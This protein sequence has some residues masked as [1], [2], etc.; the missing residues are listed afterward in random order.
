MA[1]SPQPDL[2]AD[3]LGGALP[4]AGHDPRPDHVILGH[5]RDGGRG[6]Q[7][8][9]RKR[10]WGTNNYWNTNSAGIISTP[11]AWV[12]G[13][14]AEFAAGTNATAASTVTVNGTI[15]GVAGL[16]FDNGEGPFTLTGGTLTLAGTPSIEVDATTAM[17]GSALAGTVGFTKKGTGT[18]VLSG[19]GTYTGATNVNAGILSVQSAGALGT[20]AN[21]SN[22]TVASGATLQLANNAST[23]NTGALIL[24]GTGMGGSGA[25][26]SIGGNNTWNGSMVL[27]SNATIFSATAGDTLTID[28]NYQTALTVTMGNNTLTSTVRAIRG[29]TPTSAWPETPAVSSRT[30]PGPSRSTVTTRTIREPPWSTGPWNSWLDLSRQVGMASRIADHRHRVLTSTAKVDI[31]G[32]SNP[33]GSSYT[34]QISPSSAVTINS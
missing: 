3:R 20:A 13:D 33:S 10:T 30:E 5:Q 17:I 31:W 32:A 28:A 26:Q 8:H 1:V 19:S 25:L 22:T 34:N 2:R 29:L 7:R 23:T 21:T 24:N 11:G 6:D 14:I 12:S 27:G 4:T 18:L 9:N 15:A 16:V